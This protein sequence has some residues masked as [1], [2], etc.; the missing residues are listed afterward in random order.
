MTNFIS[1]YDNALS[2]E[3]C[4]FI[5]DYFENVP[6]CEGMIKDRKKMGIL[7]ETPAAVNLNLPPITQYTSLTGSSFLLINRY[8][9]S[10]NIKK[11]PQKTGIVFNIF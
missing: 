2:S 7:R 11:S 6:P 1:L 4:K 10:A 9:F 3:E 5:I 8:F